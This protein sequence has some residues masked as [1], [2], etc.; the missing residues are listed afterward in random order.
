M[1]KK[2][3]KFQQEAL[4]LIFLLSDFWWHSVKLSRYYLLFLPIPQ[5][6]E[7]IIPPK[8]N[9]WN[10]DITNLYITKSSL[11]QTIFFAP[12]IV[13]Y[14]EKNLHLT[15]RRYGKH[16]LPVPWPSI[17]RGST[18]FQHHVQIKNGLQATLRGAKCRS[19]YFA[20]CLNE[21]LQLYK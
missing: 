20:Y 16:I 3:N 14:M 9:Q 11:Q 19:L 13:K 5:Y 12:V 10:L 4:T 8:G 18:A 1:K 21:P 6:S 15:K 17:Y 7:E 2:W